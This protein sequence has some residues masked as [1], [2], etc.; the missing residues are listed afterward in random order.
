MHYLIQ[1]YRTVLVP[2]STE[3]SGLGAFNESYNVAEADSQQSSGSEVS[4]VEKEK[5][6]DTD[7]GNSDTP[8]IEENITRL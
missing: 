6:T 2:G 7:E 3:M 4:T 5:H 1:P 8:E